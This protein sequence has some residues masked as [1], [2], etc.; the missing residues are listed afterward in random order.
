MS[1]ND[2]GQF[3]KGT[4]L[5]DIK[6]DK[7]GRLTA[8][9]LS[10]K[11]SGRKTFW[12]CICDCGN[13]KTV[14]TDSL[15]SGAI[16]SCG[17]LKKEQDK[18]NLPNGRG[19]IKHGLSKERIYNIWSNMINRCNN[20]LDSSYKN[21]G[22]RGIAVCEEWKDIDFFVEWAN[23]NGYQDTLTID[24]IDVNGNYE[25]TNCRWVTF[26]EQANN[27]RNN[28]VVKFKGKTQTLKEW[29]EETGI[30]YGTLS[31]RISLGIEPPNLFETDNFKRKDNTLLTYKEDT[32][33]MTQWA[34]RLGIKLSTLSERHRR[35]LPPE[36]I[37]YPGN[38]NSMKNKTIPR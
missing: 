23:N 5:E 34:D 28:V 20:H 32:L 10:E 24:R 21:Y 26:K 3:V 19:I 11:R 37:F 38:L 4:G 15:K 17:C 6:G 16:Q 9:K 35:G 18:I 13:M 1:R 7:F 2:R 30:P 31:T 22:G 12:E 36:K 33:T 25:P 27:K 14:R 8:L 29:S